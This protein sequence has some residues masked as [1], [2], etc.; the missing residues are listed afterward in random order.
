MSQHYKVGDAT[1]ETNEW[2]GDFA[3]FIDTTNSFFIRGGYYII[4]DNEG[5]FYYGRTHAGSTL[6]YNSFRMSIV[7]K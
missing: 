5:I 7:V 6:Q 3:N 2:N 1:Y 4:G